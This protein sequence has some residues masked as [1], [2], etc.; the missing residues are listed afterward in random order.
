[1]FTFLCLAL[2][3]KKVVKAKTLD[4][5]EKLLKELGAK[6]DCVLVCAAEKAKAKKLWKSRRGLRILD[7]EDVVQSLVLEKLE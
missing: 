6:W 2:G 1:M 7:D 4:A 5:G 3:A